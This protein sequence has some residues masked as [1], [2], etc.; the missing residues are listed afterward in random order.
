MIAGSPFSVARRLL[1]T[2]TPAGLCVTARQS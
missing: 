1:G 2:G